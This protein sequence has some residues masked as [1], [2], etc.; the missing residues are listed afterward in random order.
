MAGNI[1]KTALGSMT[2]RASNDIEIHGDRID[3]V[4]KERV[5]EKGEDGSLDVKIGLYIPSAPDAE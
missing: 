4:A 2:L 3:S 5:I 1:T